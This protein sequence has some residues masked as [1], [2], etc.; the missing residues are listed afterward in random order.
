MELQ[1]ETSL[2]YDYKDK[3]GNVLARL[4]TTLTGDG[5]TPVIM[6]SGGV[7]NTIGYDDYG[8]PIFSEIDGDE[9]ESLRREFMANAIKV[10]KEMTSDNGIDP[11]VVNM[12]GA[13]K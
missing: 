7:Q 5:S 10:Q 4:S 6:T 1:K 9:L 2:V 3:Y 13:E 8:T 11:S 12:I